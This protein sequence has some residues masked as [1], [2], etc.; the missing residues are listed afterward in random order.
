[1][2]QRMSQKKLLEYTPSELEV[3]AR[4][5]GEPFYRGRQLAAWLYQRN[6]FDLS[7]MTDLSKEFRAR[8]ADEAV[9]EPPQVVQIVPS[10]DGSRKFIL[11]L[12][13]GRR[14]HAVLMPDDDRLTLCLST[15]VGCGFACAFCFTGTMGIVRDLTAGEIVGQLL[16]VRQELPPD[17]RVTHLVFMG[18]GEPLANYKATVRALRM[19]TEPAA[20]RGLHRAPHAAGQPT[21]PVR[22][23]L[24]RNSTRHPRPRGCQTCALSPCRPHAPATHHSANLAVP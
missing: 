15:Q 18:M 19:F 21:F 10:K 16:A 20:C 5:M 24:R 9:I 7:L 14:V 11:S 13:D 1:M 23:V 17:T 22:D 8:L 12:P 4:E 3:L 6:V 2:L